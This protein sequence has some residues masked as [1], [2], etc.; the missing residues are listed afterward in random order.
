MLRGRRARGQLGPC[1]SGDPHSAQRGCPTRQSVVRGRQG[2]GSQRAKAH[3][4]VTVGGCA[5]DRRT[6]GG[7][8][9]RTNEWRQLVYS[10]IQ[11]EGAVARLQ[12][13]HPQQHGRMCRNTKPAETESPRKRKP[14]QTVAR[15][16]LESVIRNLPA[17]P[18]GRGSAGWA[19]S[20]KAKGG[21]FDPRQGTCLGCG[22]HPG[23]GTSERQPIKASLSH[24]CSCPSRPLSLNINTFK[25]FKAKQQQNS[26]NKGTPWS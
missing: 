9:G 13:A 4:W 22:F 7:V 14:E 12:T 6:E 2:G 19:S 17:A 15:E 24:G 1:H 23:Q 25:N 11:E 3:A 26:P 21:G 20:C 18:A 8:G 10:Q 16:E 5:A